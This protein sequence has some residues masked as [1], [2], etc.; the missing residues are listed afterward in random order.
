V[1]GKVAPTMLNPLPLTTALV[2]DK[3]DPPVF[4][5]VSVWVDVVF[6]T[7]LPKL[8][9]V[10]ET[11]ICAAVVVT[12]TVAE[13]DFVLSATLV[14]VTAYVPGLLGAAYI[15][16]EDIVPPV[17]DHVTEVLLAPVTAAENCRV[18]AAAIVADV[19]LIEIAT[20]G[21]DGDKLPSVALNA[22][23]P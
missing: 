15:P 16:L 1:I 3:L 21:A 9:A 12:E 6:D 22:E 20:P 5:K 17:A 7:I 13:A 14:A 18:L 8:I 2:T 19:G 10:G 23:K 11:A 4:D